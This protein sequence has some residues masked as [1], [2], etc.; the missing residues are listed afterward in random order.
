VNEA[1]ITSEPA[2]VPPPVKPEVGLSAPQWGMITFLVSEVAFFG[3]LIVAYLAYIGKDT[4][5]PKPAQV[6]ESLRLVIVN[7][8]FLLASSGTVHVADGAIRS[9]RMSSFLG[10]W[11][12][13]ILLGVAFLAGTAY[14]W[15]E[16][17]VHHHLTISTNLF[18]TTFYTLVGFHA[19]HVTVGVIMMLIFLGL[20]L[21]GAVGER[22]HTGVEL[23]SWYWH[24][25]D[26]VW[27]VVFTVVYL[28]G[29]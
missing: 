29:R 11:S 15:Y 2:L 3:T 28:V 22:N 20:A 9:G 1:Q 16:L 10:W 7:T 25:V 24:F 23:V 12:L 17:I 8:F 19:A 26:G 21:R 4:S 13:T 18:G 5:G 6:F 27:V 14:E